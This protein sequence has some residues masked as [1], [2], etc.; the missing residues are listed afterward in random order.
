MLAATGTRVELACDLR[1]AVSL[2]REGEYATVVIDETILE[3]SEDKLEALLR[4]LGSAMPVFVNLGITGRE[5]LLQEV[6][7][8]LHRAEQEQRAARRGALDA[9]SGQISSDLTGLML[10]MQQILGNSS[11]RGEVQ[12]KMEAAYQL[13]DHMR[14]RL[15]SR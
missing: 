12:Q 3:A 7:A 11:L 13:A 4:H 5:R 1:K 14:Q 15:G 6:K 8:A 9:L 10:N 2:L